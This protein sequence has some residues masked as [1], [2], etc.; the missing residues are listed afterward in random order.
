MDLLVRDRAVVLGDTL[1]C[2]DLHVGKGRTSNVEIPLGERDHLVDRLTALVDRYEPEEVVFAGD[3]LHS[4]DRVPSLAEDTVTALE[5]ICRDA[6]ARPIVTPGNHDTMLDVVWDGPTEHEYV[7]DGVE[8]SRRDGADG[9]TGPVVACHGHVEPDTAAALYVV[10]HDHP[11]ITIEGQKWHCYLYGEGVYDGAD[12]LMLPAFTKLV[13]GV[14]INRRFGTA[15]LN[16]PLVSNLDRFQ[17][18]VW[19]GNAEET[20]R[21]P[22]LGEFRNLL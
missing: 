15:G 20:R 5:R 14:S 6:G 19:D 7:L 1:V 17:P 2:A 18:I 8:W 9:E 21:F 3:L 11:T 16:S 10:G 22:P 13:A 4:F 12:V